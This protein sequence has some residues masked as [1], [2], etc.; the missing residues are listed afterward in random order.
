MT[1][2]EKLLEFLQSKNIPFRLVSHIA[3]GHSEEIAKIPVVGV[4]AAAWLRKMRVVRD[5]ND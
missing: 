5:E 3:E 1:T 2:H 4:K